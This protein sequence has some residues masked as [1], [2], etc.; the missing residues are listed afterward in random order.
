MEED[1][2]L[3]RYFKLIGP[4]GQAVGRFSGEKPIKAAS[5]AFTSLVKSSGSK[6][7][8]IDFSIVECTR[9]SRRKEYQYTGEKIKLDEGISVKINDV[10]V[11]YNNINKIKKKKKQVEKTPKVENHKKLMDKMNQNIV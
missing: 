7:G 8:E 6:D 10:E 9:N 4:D 1:N 2:K 5:K 3:T 11:T